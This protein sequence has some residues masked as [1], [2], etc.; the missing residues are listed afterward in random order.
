MLYHV[1]PH[2][3]S[4]SCPRPVACQGRR[5]LLYPRVTRR[6]RIRLIP[7]RLR[8]DQRPCANAAGH[9]WP[10]LALLRT[11]AR[12]PRDGAVTPARHPASEMRITTL[13]MLPV[14]PRAAASPSA[15][16]RRL[17]HQHPTEP[18]PLAPV[19]GHHRLFAGSRSRRRVRVVPAVASGSFPP[20]RPGRSCFTSST[21]RTALVAYRLCPPTSTHRRRIASSPPSASAPGSPSPPVPS[22][23]SP[24]GGA[25]SATRGRACFI[26]GAWGWCW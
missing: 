22:A 2:R 3:C 14:L 17:R 15:P 23:S 21:S 19:A 6:R 1:A 26:P 13:G 20:S 9:C 11:D 7:A 24:A 16:G 18:A 12:S 5:A 25:A 4:L 8:W 10:L